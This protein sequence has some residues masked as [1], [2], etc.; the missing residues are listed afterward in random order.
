MGSTGSVKLHMAKMDGET[1]VGFI[2][3][4]SVYDYSQA[5]SF[6]SDFDIDV[7]E[8]FINGFCCLTFFC[9]PE[10]HACRAFCVLS[11][12]AVEKFLKL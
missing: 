1:P 7:L 3:F 10:F 8:I 2:L 5:C 12:F 9:L 11:G 6:C 4:Y